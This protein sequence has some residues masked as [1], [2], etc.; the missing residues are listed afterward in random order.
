MLPA[1][2]PKP[3]KPEQEAKVDLRAFEY[4]F[5]K[6]Y[7]SGLDAARRPVEREVFGSSTVLFVL[8]FS[9]LG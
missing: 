2:A 9:P 6:K 3:V 5:S 1:E 7:L 4:R 8:L